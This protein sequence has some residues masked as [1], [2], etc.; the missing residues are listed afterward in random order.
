MKKKPLTIIKMTIMNKLKYI[1]LLFA[2][3][4]FSFHLKASD[5]EL[6][7]EAYE[8]NKF[9]EASQL[10]LNGMEKEGTS[11]AVLYNLGNTFYKIGKDAD[12]ILCYERARKMDPNN[13]LIKQNLKF[14]SSKVTDA[15]RSAL[16]G[17][18][19]NV[20]P[21]EE[22]IMEKIYRVIAI[23]RS[24]NNW[25]VL[26]VMAFVLFLCGVALYVFTPNVL[27]RKTGFFSGLTFLGFTIIFIVFSFMA[28]AEYRNK[29]NVILM[30]E[31]A[32]L[33]KEPNE[34]SSSSTSMLHG[35]TKLK[36][37]EDKKGADGV[38]WVKVR[39][40]NDNIGW[41]KKNSVEAI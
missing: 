21:E 8:Q 23:E 10:Y 18:A 27:A 3:L 37:L 17:R 11:A 12:A 25:A 35:G 39:L 29:E 31:R 14:V 41:I 15:N 36:I 38:E 26:A 32:E 33:L 24:S 2:V 28:A 1:Y 20:E 19:G 34:K 40:N 13:K 5:F 9:E 30:E 4:S 6:A 22:T 7:Q 16:Q